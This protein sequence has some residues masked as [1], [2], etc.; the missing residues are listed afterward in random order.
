MIAVALAL[1]QAVAPRAA[2]P[3]SDAPLYITGGHYFDVTGQHMVPNPGIVVRAGKLVRIGPPFYA[4]DT[5]GAQAVTLDADAYLLPGF[6]D[7]HAHYAI[8]LFG[9]GRIDDVDV[10][11]SLFLA[12]GVTTTFPA[13]EMQ[14]ERMR[15][16]RLRIERGEQP[17]PRLISS[18]PYFGT[19][20]PGWSQSITADSIRAEVD[21][22]VMQG[23]RAFKAKGISAQ[24][25]APLIAAAHAH[26]ATVTGHL[27]SGFR[28]SVN[29]RDAIL[30]GIDRIEHFLGGDF[31]SADR[32][33][34]ASLVSFSP[35]VPEFETIARLYIERGVFFDATLSAYGYYGEKEPIVFTQW[36]DEQ[37]FLTPYMRHIIAA[38]APRS[39]N[40]QFETIYHV[41]RRTIRAFHDMGGAELITLGTDH[42]SWGEFLSPFSVHRELHA[43]VL[44]GIPPAS[45][46]RIATLN[47]ARALGWSDRLGSI[48]VGK[49]AD[50]VVVRGNPL[51]DIRN[52]RNV[53]H[54]IKAGMLYDPAE[55]ARAVA[56]RLGPRTEDEARAW[57]WRP[58][59]GRE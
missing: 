20:R 25:L 12:N 49:W 10:Y 16:L 54:V 8:D 31:I 5:A 46:L 15:E 40:R 18:G 17:G 29:P 59:T 27:D 37:K 7:L 42:P 45:A 44:A 22:W 43:F 47:G 33:A 23:A 56:G 30:M 19:A 6:I 13:G 4:A 58:A 48:E 3:A 24:H 26:G 1:L 2:A 57:G 53:R 28:G 35:D 9:G 14:P 52:T 41:K 50:M 36:T 34:Y 11:P 51:D 39:V 32:S 55:L 38:R 21:Y